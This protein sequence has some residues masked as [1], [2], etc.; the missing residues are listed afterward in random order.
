MVKILKII[1][2]GL[3]FNSIALALNAENEKQLYMGCYINSKQYLGSV[4][5]KEY[6]L[7]TIQMLSIKY[8]DDE[9]DKIFKKNPEEIIKKTK[10]AAI[11]C[12]NNKKATK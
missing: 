11:H 2:T 6:C 8:S 10:F 5:A 12:E 7:C 3:F 4:K 1:V 9:I